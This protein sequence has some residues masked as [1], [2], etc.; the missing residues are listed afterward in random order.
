[1]SF[2][3]TPLFTTVIRLLRS[4]YVVDA[5]R[6]TFAVL[7]PLFLFFEIGMPNTGIGISVGALMACMTD[8][9]GNRNDK[10][11]GALYTIVSFFIVAFLTSWSSLNYPSLMI[12]IV[13]FIVFFCTMLGLYGQRIGA[14]GLMV[15]ILATFTIG[16]KSENSLL[17]AWYIALGSIWYFFISM[18]QIYVYPYR[19]LTRV[20][21]RTKH[22]T[23]ELLELRA[24][25]YNL[26]KDLAGFNQRNIDLHL[27]LANQHELIRQLLLTDK[28]ALSGSKKGE[29][30]LKVSVSL[31]DLYE[32]SSAVHYDYPYIRRTLGDTGILP[33][34]ETSILSIAK[35]LRGADVDLKDFDYSSKA[36]FGDLGDAW[37][38]TSKD[39]VT[40]VL[41]NISAIEQLVHDILNPEQTENISQSNHH[42]YEDFISDKPKGLNVF[43]NALN[44]NSPVFRFSLRLTGLSLFALI[45]IY[46]LSEEKYSYWLLLTMVIVSRPFYSHTVQRNI[47]RLVGS[48]IGIIL[49]WIVVNFLPL[50]F[51]LAISGLG[52]FLFFVFNRPKYWLSVITITTTV[53]VCLN[54][55]QGDLWTLL[56]ERAYF[57]IGALVLCLVATF[58]FP[59]WNLPRVKKLLKDVV[60]A[61]LDYFLKASN[62][63][64]DDLESIHQLRLVRKESHQKLA[65]LSEAIMTAK[66]EPFKKYVNWEFLNKI[67]I[68]TYQINV[69]TATYAGL[70][71]DGKAILHQSEINEIINNLSSSL[72]ALT[73]FDISR[74]DQIAIYSGKPMGLLETSKTL[75][76]AC[77]VSK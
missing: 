33:R 67:Q 56:S 11:Q 53:I 66:K 13:A 65:L 62:V 12:F 40:Q 24:E 37:E 46:F 42:D 43:A 55:I 30:L 70:K 6:N 29:L 39:L 35:K 72:V 73:D 14:I 74:N 76:A 9:P 1:M 45:L 28:K 16:L 38:V 60:K 71:K 50:S 3:A 58:V 8:L 49:A 32:Q 77:Q 57:T 69:L 20:I 25:G 4:E 15:I 61:N 17:Y 21:H 52:L 18:L 48:A 68:L 64:P 41:V 36:H 34:I 47:E 44:F 63:K 54:V 51:Q 23:A 7:A 5:L 19:S 75:V 2:I 22:L 26:T 31:I 10:I 27:K 59:I